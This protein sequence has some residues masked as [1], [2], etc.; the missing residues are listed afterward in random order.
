MKK[1]IP[2][3]V[4]GAMVLGF[5]ALFEIVLGRWLGPA[6]HNRVISYLL[7]IFS[8]VVLACIS[9]VCIVVLMVPKFREAANA[10]TRRSESSSPENAQPPFQLKLNAVT[11]SL[12]ERTPD[13]PETLH[14]RAQ[15]ERDLQAVE[16]ASR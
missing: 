8:S 5:A 1:T 7:L 6:A 14:D 11:G 3:F 10:L 16:N 9:T 13:D 15:L 12:L 2:V 4:L